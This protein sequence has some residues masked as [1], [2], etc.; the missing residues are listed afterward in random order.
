VLVV[1][2]DA[3]QRVALS[4]MLRA[5]GHEVDTA[6]DGAQA[7]Q[8]LLENPASIVFTDWMMPNMS[9]LELIQKIRERDF[10]RYV[11]VILCSGKDSRGDLIEGMRRGAD[12]YL[13]KPVSAD[14]VS[15]RISSGER[16]IQLEKRL[17][18]EKRRLED[19]NQSLS[20]AYE[21]IRADLEAAAEMQRALLPPPAKIHN[22]QFEWLFCPAKVVA[23]DILSFFPLNEH[24]VGF[25]QVDVSGHGI[26]AAM[27][28]VL[29]SKMLATTPIGSSLLKS[30][31]PEAPGYVITPP[32]K[33]IGE[34]NQRMQGNGD[35]YFTMVYGMVDLKAK[36]LKFSQAGHPHPIYVRRGDAAIALGNGG[37]PV[38]VLPSMEYDLTGLDVERGDRLFLTSDGIT[39]CT[40][41]A[42]KQFGMQRLTLFIEEHCDHSLKELL[43]ALQT[44][45]RT[46][47]G[48]DDFQDDLSVVATEIL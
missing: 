10:G 32:N 19:V 7:W 47:V 35:M 28:S 25:Y 11:Y 20:E 1:D 37:F 9:G 8:N 21:T 44:E 43:A 48:G 46:W 42:G 14:E 16:V 41:P 38:G 40:N 5:R 3:M 45:L 30:A 29:L 26:P 36:R 39:E 23:G 24:T 33:V 17:E 27:F 22:M 34:L 15:V 13:R 12:D 18:E 6:R 4:S 31:T 2:D